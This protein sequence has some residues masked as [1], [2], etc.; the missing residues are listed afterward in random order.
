M[1]NYKEN[2]SLSGYGECCREHTLAFPGEPHLTT[3]R[4]HSSL[5]SAAPLRPLLHPG[6]LLVEVPIIGEPM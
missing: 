4:P 6:F 2:V 3:L 1:V 5:V